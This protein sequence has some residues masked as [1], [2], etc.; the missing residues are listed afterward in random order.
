M[1]S[2]PART[3][4]EVRH[5]LQRQRHEFGCL[6]EESRDGLRDNTP[7]LG[8]RSSLDQHLEVELL[9]CQPLQSVL[10]DGAE[11]ASHR[12]PGAAVL[13]GRHRPASRV[14]VA[15]DTL[16]V[17]RRQDFAN[18]VEHRVVIQRIANLLQLLME[19]LQHTALDGVGRHEIEDEAVLALSIA[20]DSPHP[21][22]EP[23]RIPGNV[24][25]EQDV[26]HL[27]VDALARRFSGDENLDLT[28]S[29]LLL[30]VKARAGLITGTRLHPTVNAADA[31]APGRQPLHEVVQSV[32]KLREE[33]QA[34]IRVIEEAFLVKQ[35]LELR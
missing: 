9:T 16:D 10:A 24:V 12:H 20:V 3:C 11:L 27:E 6:A 22:L 15:Q 31:E 33:E 18:N 32:F 7:L 30:S 17:R 21:L 1:A 34:L 8:L 13:R 26:A 19:A 35:L 4:A 25:V 5:V 23:V 2:E 29:K 14:V 28:F